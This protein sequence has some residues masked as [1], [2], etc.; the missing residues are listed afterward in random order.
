MEPLIPGDGRA[1]AGDHNQHL[2][3]DA[4]FATYLSSEEEEWTPPRRQ[5][6]RAARLMSI[7]NVLGLIAGLLLTYSVICST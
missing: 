7:L 3:S 2:N 4:Q 1:D 6:T 5:P